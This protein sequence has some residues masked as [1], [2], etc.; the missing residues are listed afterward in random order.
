MSEPVTSD[1]SVTRVGTSVRNRED[2]YT[3]TK[4]TKTQ[5]D[6]PK[7]KTEI[8]RYSDAKKSNPVV[9]GE[10][11]S[12]TGKISFND[13]AS[14]T[15]Q[16]YSSSLGKTSSGQIKSISSSVTSNAAD[17]AALNASAGQS[18]QA[19]GSGV[20]TQ[21]QGGTR[22]KRGQG[23]RPL[24]DTTRRGGGVNSSANGGADNKPVP[25]SETEDGK[26]KEGTRNAGFPTLVFPEGLGSVDRDV[27]KI[28]MLQYKASG[29]GDN[30]GGVSSMGGGRADLWKK[31]MIGSVTLPV[32]GGISDTNA[33]DWGSGT[34]NPIQA[35]A[36]NFAL[37][38]LQDGFKAG[39]DAAV[40]SLEEAKKGGADVKKGIASMIA[41]SATQI[42]KQALQRG[43]GMV[44]NPNMEVLFNG[45]QLR[46]FGFSFKLS[47]RSQRE[48]Q[49]VVKIIKFFK[50]GMS[51]IR[52]QTNFYLKAPHT[53]RLKYLN[54][55]GGDQ[56]KYLNKFKE[57]ALQNATVQYTPDGNYNTFVD[58]V[59][60]SYS[61]QLTFAELTPIYND[62]YG[63]GAFDASIGF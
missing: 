37:K 54:R 42:G 14:S 1:I 9:I 55:A 8:V 33:V 35:A 12:K 30:S 26:P 43:E 27:L 60:T 25:V 11:D 28:D 36:A 38:T 49:T 2:I 23:G 10:R 13:N 15:E 4:V 58:G 29:F 21:Q 6:P 48:A 59:M 44:L 39:A 32:P 3:A 57:C 45:P 18:N 53:F 46:T 7:Y 56:Q 62:D 24:G 47:P 51:P 16:K 17:K 40:G 50:Q 41:G 52:S 34:M 20:S 63:N 5:S 31:E 19:L 22:P 61:L